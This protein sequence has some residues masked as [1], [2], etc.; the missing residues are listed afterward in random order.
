MTQEEYAELLAKETG[1]S[2]VAVLSLLAALLPL[3]QKLP[4]F[5]KKKA[6][7]KQ[8]IISEFQECC[9]NTINTRCPFRLR[10]TINKHG[11]SAGHFWHCMNQVAFAHLD[12]VS[13]MLVKL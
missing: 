9:K 10:R 12:D 2:V 5:E 7:L 13:A 3:I 8:G 1:M 4:C 6:K 11:Q